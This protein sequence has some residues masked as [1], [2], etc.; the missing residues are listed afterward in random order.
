[1]APLAN[2]AILAYCTANAGSERLSGKP[3]SVWERGEGE[4]RILGESHSLTPALFSVDRGAGG[5]PD[6]L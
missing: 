6:S 3:R 1:M 4:N 2:R 5:C